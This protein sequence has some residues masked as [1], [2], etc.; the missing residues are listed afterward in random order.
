MS[1]KNQAIIFFVVSVVG[2][3]MPY[4]EL[5]PFIIETRG[6]DLA[7]FFEE[8]GATRSSRLIAW[9][10]AIA[11]STFMLFMLFDKNRPKYWWLSILLTFGVGVSCSFPF[12][13]GLKAQIAKLTF[14]LQKHP[15]IPSFKGGLL[16]KL[17][18]KVPLSRGI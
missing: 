12:Y 15:P 7:L 4:T 14:L 9:D 5:I 8:I 3:V 6:F 2:F 1:P 13:L 18:S 11:G 17:Y 16:V 10:L